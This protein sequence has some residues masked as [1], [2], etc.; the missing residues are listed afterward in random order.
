LAQSSINLALAVGRQALPP[1][2][3]GNQP[4]CNLRCLM[5]LKGA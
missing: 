2:S 4:A 3:I 5:L 1:T